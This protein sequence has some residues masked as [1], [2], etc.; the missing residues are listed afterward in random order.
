MIDARDLLTKVCTNNLYVVYIENKNRI[1]YT[2]LTQFSLHML[3]NRV[4]I[5]SVF[6]NRHPKDFV[7]RPLPIRDIFD[8]RQ[9]SLESFE[10]LPWSL[11]YG[12]NLFIYLKI[13]STYP[14]SGEV[15]GGRCIFQGSSFHRGCACIVLKKCAL[16]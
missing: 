12:A 2:V 5:V 3:Q 6:E 13:R 14:F 10:S 15:V 4:Q 7:Q 9:D 16:L 11:A 1:F 8:R